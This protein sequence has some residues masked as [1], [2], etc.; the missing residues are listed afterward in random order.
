M[1][2]NTNNTKE[3]SKL[4]KEEWREYTQNVW[5]IM[6]ISH[7][8]HPAVFNPEI[9]HRLI[10]MFSFVGETVLD[11]FA[12]TGTTMIV[13]RKLNRNSIGIELNKEYCKM[14]EEELQQKS[15]SAFESNNITS[16][17][18][19]NADSLEYLK[20][21]EEKSIDLIT[22]SPPYWNK[23]QYSENSNDLGNIDEY[24][25]FIDSMHV[26]FEECLRILKPGRRLC[27]VTA[28]VHQDTE[29][30]LQRFPLASDYNVLAR[31]IGFLL[32]GEVIWS[33]ANTGGKWGSY[34]AQRPIFGSY[35]YPPNFCFKDLHEYILIY[36]KKP[37]TKK[38]M[39]KPNTKKEKKG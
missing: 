16:H 1:P 18:I 4:T 15:L 19:I 32:V 9:P 26:F 37:N 35:P 38:R 8:N 6:N 13:S 5:S 33:K 21:I 11:P 29:Y 27:I 31:K 2:D 39:K 10:K 30:G 3:A 7:E 20:Q 17:D 24:E 34:G 36:R 28:N 12:G 23:A 22:T 14:I 25:Q